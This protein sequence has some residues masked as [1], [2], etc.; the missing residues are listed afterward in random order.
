MFSRLKISEKDDDIGLPSREEFEKE[1]KVFFTVMENLF[2]ESYLNVGRVLFSTKVGF[3]KY[4][5][6]K[7]DEVKDDPFYK[8]IETKEDFFDRVKEKKKFLSIAESYVDDIIRNYENLDPSKFY[9]S[10]MNYIDWRG[11]YVKRRKDR[12]LYN[13][14]Y[15]YGGILFIEEWADA[16]KRFLRDLDEKVNTDWKRKELSTF[17]GS[18]KGNLK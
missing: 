16:F 14:Y 3:S 15:K 2:K 18:F 17:L 1:R 9:G 7:W 5:P 4:N 6:K 10:M 8:G 12:N 13:K 11:A